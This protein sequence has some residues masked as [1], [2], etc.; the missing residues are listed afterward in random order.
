MSAETAQPSSIPPPS[1]VSIRILRPDSR[2]AALIDSYYFVE[3]DR[4]TTDMV[5]S[6]PG[7]I[8]FAP[9]G[10]WVQ[11]VNGVVVPTPQR[12][13]L[14]GPTSRTAVFGPTGPGLMIGAG[15]TP[16]GWVQLFDLPASQLSNKVAELGAVVG[17]ADA[18]ALATAVEGAPDDAAA[19]RLLD[20]WLIAR[21]AARPRA[22]A[23]IAAVHRALLTIPD[24]VAAFAVAAGVSERT[25]HRL[26]A[27]AFGF[28]PKALLRQKRFQRTLE[29]VRGVLDRPLSGLIDDDYFDQAHF[30]REF[31][32]F[33]GMSPTAYYNSPREIMRRAAEVRRAVNGRGI[34]GLHPLV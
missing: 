33:M 21:A 32:E 29:R 30:N 15:L 14:F 28:P 23:R 6:S 26:C 18:D 19:G 25:L 3:T 13:A 31:R 11:T 16:L 7:N 17:T 1:P 4:A 9:R 22:D 5:L 27:Q 12:S 24:D 8:R 2:L 10:S 34:Q 20:D